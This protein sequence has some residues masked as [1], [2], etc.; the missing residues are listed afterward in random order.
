MSCSE[1]SV[2]PGLSGE[3]LLWNSCVQ[4]QA[5]DSGSGVPRRYLDVAFV[6]LRNTSGVCWVPEGLRSLSVPLPAGLSRHFL[7]RT[8][9]GMQF[10]GQISLGPGSLPQS[11][12]EGHQ[13]TSFEADGHGSSVTPVQIPFEMTKGIYF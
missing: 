9:C 1:T 8:V 12:G 2:A 6:V 11:C 10:L 5:L 3:A 7:G 13:T 4:G